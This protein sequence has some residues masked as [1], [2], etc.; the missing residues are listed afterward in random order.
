MEKSKREHPLPPPLRACV[1]DVKKKKKKRRK[2][3]SLLIDFLTL[4]VS[5]LQLSVVMQIHTHAH[6]HEGPSLNTLSFFLTDFF[7]ISLP[8]T[9]Y[10]THFNQTP[11]A[12]YFI[13]GHHETCI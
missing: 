10:S 4:F 3:V 12:R 5:S 9:N 1:C 6:Y 2:S 8:G 11:E 7:M 13:V